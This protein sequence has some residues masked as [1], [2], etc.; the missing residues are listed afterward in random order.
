MV[1]RI[2]IAASVI[3]KDMEGRSEKKNGKQK[4]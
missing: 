2:Y 3:Q 1:V 4:L